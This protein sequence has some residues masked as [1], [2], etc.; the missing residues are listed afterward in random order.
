MV[1][2]MNRRLIAA[3]WIAGATIPLLAA[4]LFVVGCCALPFHH[5]MHKVMPVC[6][7]ALD[8]FRIDDAA[9]GA[10][11]PATPAHEKQEPVKIAVHAGRS[12]RLPATAT[13]PP[14]TA[15][16]A[17]YRSFITLGAIRCDRDVG[18]HLLV[19]TFRI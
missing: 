17:G 3:L 11:Q 19:D 6:R 8:A 18:L 1:L 4:T 12:W 14:L 2:P 15:A 10:E 5:L 9:D 13:A 16:A 7:M